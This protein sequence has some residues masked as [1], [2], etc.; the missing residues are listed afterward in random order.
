M[1]YH[2]EFGR[3]RSNCVCT[4]KGGG[5]KQLGAAGAT[6][7]AVKTSPHYVE[8]GHSVSKGESTN[9][10]E[11]QKLVSPGILP[12]WYKICPSQRASPCRVF[13]RFMSN[14][15][16][17]ITEIRQK[18]I[19]LFAF[20]LSRSFKVISTDTN[21]SST[22]DSLITFHGNHGPISYHFR[23]ERRF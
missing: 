3:S 9:R 10:G 19:R 17:V 4:S 2:A 12:L 14:D 11:L 23:D 7:I 20:R 8:I 6:P 15:T 5:G 22:Y 13:V 21:R 18:I 16:T 1:C